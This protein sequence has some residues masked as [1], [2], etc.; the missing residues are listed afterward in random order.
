MLTS[1][2]TGLPSMTRW[3]PAASVRV[4]SAVPL[5]IELARTAEPLTVG[6]VTSTQ[7]RPLRSAWFST[8]P[9]GGAVSVVVASL[10]VKVS[11]AAWLVMPLVSPKL[12]A[13]KVT[14]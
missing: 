14:V 1:I 2:S 3:S 10:T 6:K 4:K 12:P 8:P 11:E 5:V 9:V 7:P 13:R